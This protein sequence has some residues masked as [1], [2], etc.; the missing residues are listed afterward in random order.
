MTLPDLSDSERIALFLD[1][2]GTLVAIAERPDEVR[3]DLS[4]RQALVHLDR[5]NDEKQLKD[6]FTWSGASHIVYSGFMLML[7]QQPNNGEPAVPPYEWARWEALTKEQDCFSTK[8]KFAAPPTPDRP[9]WN[10]ATRRCSP[11][12]DPKARSRSRS[13]SRAIRAS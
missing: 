9:P 2:D 4:T 1:F 5:V 8:V 12:P 10:G 7:D 13:G 6:C 3:L 11:S